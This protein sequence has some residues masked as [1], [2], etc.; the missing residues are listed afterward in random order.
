MNRGERRRMTCG[1][2]GI[3]LRL[4]FCSGEQVGKRTRVENDGGPGRDRLSLPSKTAS[5]GREFDCSL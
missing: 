3:F 5:Q 2:S 4:P 1:T